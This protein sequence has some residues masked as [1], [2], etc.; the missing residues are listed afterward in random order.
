MQSASSAGFRGAEIVRA[1]SVRAAWQE[2][3]MQHLASFLAWLSTDSRTYRVARPPPLACWAHTASSSAAQRHV[4]SAE[5][6]AARPEQA[7]KPLAAL[8]PFEALVEPATG[9]IHPACRGLL[10]IMRRGSQLLALRV[11]HVRQEQAARPGLGSMAPH[12][13]APLSIPLIAGWSGT[14]GIW[15]ALWFSQVTLCSSLA[16]A[17]APPPV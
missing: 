10:P 15:S 8:G 3:C 6:V 1:A 2:E 7:G 14:N 9:M 17:S 13:A 12:T 16:P 5:G 11:P 4:V